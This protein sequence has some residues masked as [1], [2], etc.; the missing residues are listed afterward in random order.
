MNIGKQI[1]TLRKEKNITQ[2]ILAAEMGVTVGAVSKWENGISIP[3]IF[4]PNL[5]NEPVFFRK[6][7]KIV[8][9]CAATGKTGRKDAWQPESPLYQ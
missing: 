8:F 7:I 9:S 3:D 6:P 5:R 2:E 4:M 1:Q